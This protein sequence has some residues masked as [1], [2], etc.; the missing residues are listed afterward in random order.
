LRPLDRLTVQSYW[1][2]VT[3][4]FSDAQALPIRGN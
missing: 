4:R 3:K 1:P 2:L